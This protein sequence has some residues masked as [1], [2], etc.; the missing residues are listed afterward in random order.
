MT[1]VCVTTGSLALASLALLM[2]RIISPGRFAQAL[3]GIAIGALIAVGIT[4]AGGG[5]G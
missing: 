4:Y 3:S 2:Q 1:A 5:L